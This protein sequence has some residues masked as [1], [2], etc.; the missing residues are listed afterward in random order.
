MQSFN[1]FIMKSLILS[2]SFV[3]FGSTVTLDNKSASYFC[4]DLANEVENS[5]NGGRG[6]QDDSFEI[7]QAAYEACESVSLMYSV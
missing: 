5:L 7:W 1:L 3:F 6:A 4:M 2:M